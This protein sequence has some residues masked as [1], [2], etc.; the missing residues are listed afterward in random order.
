MKTMDSLEPSQEL[1]PL[2]DTEKHWEDWRSHFPILSRKTYLNSCSL[3][4]LS[5]RAED[6]IRQFH[7]EWHSEGASA[8]YEIWLSRLD[9]LRGRVAGMLN[10]G[11]DELGYAASVSAALTVMASTLD[12]TRRPKIV[13]AEPDFPTIAYQWMARSDAEVVQARSQDQATVD[14]ERYADLVDHRT[15]ALVTSH[16]FYGSGAIQDLRTLA[17][18]AHARGALLIVDA[19]QSAGQL[20]LD[21]KA[22]GVDVLIAGPLKWLMGGP[23]LAYLYVRRELIPELRPTVAGWF[24]AKRQFQ[25]DMDGFEF[26]DDARRYEL[27]TPALPTV[28]AAL[29]GQE[30]I[31][32]IGV[33]RIRER[34]RM[35]TERLIS[36]AGEAGFPMRIAPNP[37][38]RSAIVM[39]RH[40]DA[41][42]AVEHLA[43]KGIIVDA[44]DGHVRISPHFYNTEEEVDLVV[45]ELRH[46]P[47]AHR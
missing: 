17:E 15:A 3:G 18:I 8:W 25:F 4:A 7:Q 5:H 41:R 21:V 30:I 24:G 32:H 28:H 9:E 13:V 12:Y 1:P 20:P 33:P 23:G 40:P 44:R 34:N 10:A 45:D 27:G 19:Y 42:G 2:T 26:R 14:M 29:G 6:R 39:V 37:E 11:P 43:R 22:G 36:A 35:L 47:G 31:D 16:V 38:S 46:V